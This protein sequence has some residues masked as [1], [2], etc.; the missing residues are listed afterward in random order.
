MSPSLRPI[1]LSQRYCYYENSTGI[2]CSSGYDRVSILDTI[3]VMNGSCVRNWLQVHVKRIFVGGLSSD[4][5][6]E[7]LKEYFEQFGKV[8]V[9]EC[10]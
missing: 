5:T 9:C 2:Y 6:E 10:V 7:D 4:T 8:S 3:H 1:F